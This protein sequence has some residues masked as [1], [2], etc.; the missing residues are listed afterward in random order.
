MQREVKCLSKVTEGPAA[1][2][3]E[4]TL[5]AVKTDKNKALS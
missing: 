2:F 5:G 1:R 4:Q 3:S